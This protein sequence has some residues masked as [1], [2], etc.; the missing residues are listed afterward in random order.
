MAES[1]LTK[2]YYLGPGW[3]TRP[4]MKWY[5]AVEL[6]NER[7]GT[8]QKYFAIPVKGTEVYNEVRDIQHNPQEIAK[9]GEAEP[10]AQTIAQKEGLPIQRQRKTRLRSSKRIVDLV[11]SGVADKEIQK[12]EKKIERL[13]KQKDFDKRLIDNLSKILPEQKKETTEEDIKKIKI[14][15]ETYFLDT[16]SDFVYKEN[17]INNPEAP[18]V[19]DY[20]FNK[21]NL[22]KK[23]KSQLQKQK[24]KIAELRTLSVAKSTFLEGNELKNKIEELKKLSKEELAKKIQTEGK[25]ET[26]TYSNKKTSKDELIDVFLR[27][28]GLKKGPGNPTTEGVRSTKD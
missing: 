8:R 28:T 22:F 11:E 23:T 7:I 19:G 12:I 14:N 9:T 27:R 17:P 10:S 25:W 21:L 13:E 3:G 2:E 4:Y 6:W 16:I 18:A 26:F 1:S 20:R 5:K 15:G 24:E